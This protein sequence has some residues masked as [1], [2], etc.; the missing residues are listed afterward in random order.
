MI[1]RAAGPARTT[2][3]AG[4]M[5]MINGNIMRAM[6]KPFY[7]VHGLLDWMFPIE[8]AY[9]AQSELLNAGANLTFRAI[10]GLS[11]TYCRAEHPDLITWFNPKL[12]IPKNG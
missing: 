1:F 6:G 3:I 11:H 9:M 10:D 2:K 12:E 5:N 7:V 4:K 8:T